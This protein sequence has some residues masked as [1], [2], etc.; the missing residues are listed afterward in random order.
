[1]SAFIGG[2]LDAIAQSADRID[3][4]AALAVTT[5]TETSSAAEML[6]T[7][8][9]EAMGDLMKKFDLIAGELS[10]DINATHTQLVSAD[11]KGASRDNAVAIKE[12]LQGQ[13]NTVLGNATT[14]LGLERDAFNTRAGAIVDSV[15]QEFKSVMSQIDVEYTNLAQA[16]R[17]TRE[18][19]L[20]ADATIKMG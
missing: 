18:N 5:G 12:Q 8:V 2:N 14:N 3:T 4:S 15:N 6:Q 19:L 17:Q 16:S 11:W 13:V 1:M 10:K 20:A 9:N 7:A